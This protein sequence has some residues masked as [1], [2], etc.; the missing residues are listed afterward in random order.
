MNS[1]EIV[2]VPYFKKGNGIHIKDGK[3]LEK[4]DSV[5]LLKVK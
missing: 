5:R 3:P 4:E 1:L 2:G